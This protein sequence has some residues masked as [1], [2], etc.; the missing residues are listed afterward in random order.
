MKDA[1]QLSVSMNGPA[2]IRDADG[3]PTSFRVLSAGPML[4]T[5]AGQTMKLDVSNAMLSDIM[6]FHEAKGSLIPMDAEHYLARVATMMGKDEGTVMKEQPLLGE[7]AAAGL[8]RL[9]LKDDGIWAH[10]EKLADRARA[11]LAG[12]GDKIYGYFSPMLRGLVTK[13]TRMTSIALTNQPATNKLDLLAANDPD[14]PFAVNINNTNTE[15][16]KMK[17]LFAR[18]M[19]A[20]G[21]DDK[22]FND[23]QA[24]SLLDRAADALTSL[25]KALA[26]IR[27][28]LG[29][30]DK[31]EPMTVTAKV[32]AAIEKGKIDTLALT[33]AQTKLAGFESAH[34]KALLDDAE[35]AGKLTAPLRKFADENLKDT[36]ALT[37]YIGALPVIVPQ[38]SVADKTQ[39]ASG[40]DKGLTDA[41]ITVARACG[42]DPAEVAKAN[43][44]T[45]KA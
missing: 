16:P 5:E 43:G 8:L 10:V 21:L 27:D 29:L 1:L 3:V 4:F 20:L 35:K 6:Q 15:T 37:D 31:D 42:L 17:L 34:R 23:D 41:E 13:P 36:K 2:V 19:A 28:A 40:D 9:E 26:P 25:G 18:L 12:S 33:D 39:Q 7:Q 22:G 24:Q 38:G 45:F 30:T 14:R 11:L 44:K 32:L